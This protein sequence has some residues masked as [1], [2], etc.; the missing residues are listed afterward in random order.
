MCLVVA[1]PDSVVAAHHHYELLRLLVG[2]S[3]DVQWCELI[4]HCTE[5][6]NADLPL[7][8]IKPD[9]FIDVLVESE[10]VIVLRTNEDLN[11][12]LNDLLH[13]VSLTTVRWTTYPQVALLLGSVQCLEL[14][15]HVL[16]RE[17]LDSN[18]GF[19]LLFCQH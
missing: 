1:V 7:E 17:I 10:P 3:L 15:H 16:V 6:L 12:F 9:D 13:E 2:S 5:V 8:L 4:T 14:I 19:L 11:S 18:P